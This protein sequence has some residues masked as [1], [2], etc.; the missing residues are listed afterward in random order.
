MNLFAQF[1]RKYNSI[2]NN[3]VNFKNNKLII[4]DRKKFSNYKNNQVNENEQNENNSDDE[5]DKLILKDKSDDDDNDI[6]EQSDGSIS[7]NSDT[8]HTNKPDY[9]EINTPKPMRMKRGKYDSDVV[10]M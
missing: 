7:Y 5:N 9:D 10:I 3:F 8:V 1:V 4:F 2:N 6:T